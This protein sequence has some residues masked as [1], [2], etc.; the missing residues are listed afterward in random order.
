MAD[1]DGY[2]GEDVAATYDELLAE[3][4]V[5]AVV[6]PVVEVLAELAG[7]GSAL[8]FGV[9]TGRIALPL[10][11]RGVKVAGIDLS[12]A[13]VRR[14]H[15]KPGGER[16]EVAIGDF[17]TTVAG[18]GFALVYLLCNTIMNVTTQA[19]Q[20][21]CFRN[22]AAHLRP[23][24]RFVIDVM[25]PELRRLPPGN[26]TVV[27]AKTSDH[28]GFDEYEVAGQGLV[29]HHFE[30]VHGTWRYQ[31]VPFRYVWP[32]ELDLMAQLAGMRLRERWGGWQREPFTSESRKHI[33]VWEKPT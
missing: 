6:D 5:P 4:S 19:G 30:R 24:G 18:N 9:G 10:A 23:G 15:A 16:V 28:F 14:L 20:L 22:A 21:A 29:S 11:A 1:E 33:S 8:E 27:F 3:E 25:I 2:F 12:R 7:E 31:A 17:A 13:M 26:T 32:A